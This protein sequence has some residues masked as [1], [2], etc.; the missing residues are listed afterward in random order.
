MTFTSQEITLANLT[1]GTAYDYCLTIVYVPNMTEVG[2]QFCGN[3]TTLSSAGTGRCIYS[4]DKIDTC[5]P[6]NMRTCNINYI[7]IAAALFLI[8]KK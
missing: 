6:A 5:T 1:S 7:L 8:V 3:F 2:E 4:V